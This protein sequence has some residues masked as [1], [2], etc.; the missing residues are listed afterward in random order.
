M[1]PTKTARVEA[2]AAQHERLP[3]RGGI[4][5]ELDHYLEAL[6]RTPGALPGAIA[7]EQ[8]CTAGKFTLSAMLDGPPRGTVASTTAD[9]VLFW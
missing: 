4:R 8:A 6:V 3:T 7:L 1:A 5:L 2:E 9:V